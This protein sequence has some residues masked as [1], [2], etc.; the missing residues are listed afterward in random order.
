MAN[1]EELVL[2]ISGDS[3]EAQVSIEELR[4]HLGSLLSTITGGVVSGEVFAHA[5]EQ[6]GEKALEAVHKVVEFYTESVKAAAEYESAEARLAGAVAASGQA[7]MESLDAYHE[8][9]ETIATSTTTSKT[10]ALEMEARFIQLGGVGKDKMGQATQA[11]LDLA[12]GLRIDLTTAVTQVSK[13]LE[14]HVTGLQRMGVVLDAARVQAEGANYIFEELNKRFGGQAQLQAATFAGQIQRIANAWEEFEIAIGRTATEDPV[15]Q[16]ALH[17]L[18]ESLEGV[19][20]ATRKNAGAFTD[21]AA[22]FLEHVM[23]MHGGWY[24]LA[25]AVKYYA[26]QTDLAYEV[27]AMTDALFQKLGTTT[28]QLAAREYSASD[29]AK[30]GLEAFK[31]QQNAVEAIT[32]LRAAQTQGLAAW[33]KAQVASDFAVG[34][35][36][37]VIA[38]AIGANVVVVEKY[39]EQLKHGQEESKKFSQALE[40]ARASTVA[41]SEADQII[42]ATLKERGLSEEQ[43]ALVIG[44]TTA[45][46]KVAIKADEAR[47]KTA[48]EMTTLRREIEKR[49]ND[50]SLKEYEH[51]QKEV[52]AAVDRVVKAIL[53]GDAQ[54]TDL[55]RQTAD[56]V[57]RTTLTSTD[58]QIF[59]INEWAREQKLAFKGTEEERRRFDAA[60]EASAAQQ[61]DALYIDYQAIEKA[62]KAS[63]Q[64]QADKAWTT[65]EFMAER[66]GEF[67]ER[68]I[69]AAR[70]AAE[71]A[72]QAA[73]DTVG[74]W[75]RTDQILG[76]V[77]TI[78]SGIKGKF[79]E[80]TAVV[81]RTF[82][83]IGERLAEGDILGAVVAGITGAITAITK[84][85]GGVSAEEKKARQD[86]ANFETQ[87]HSTLTATQKLEAGNVSWKETTI[88]VRDAYL[89]T[90][91]SEAEAEAAVKRLW[92]SS[93]F[94]A[95]ATKAAID[96]I[97]AV[98]AEQKQRQLDVDAAFKDFTSAVLSAG[99]TLPEALRPMVERLAEMKGL[100]KD[101]R[102]ALLALTKDVAPDFAKLEEIAKK[103]GISLEG[104]G[105]K[106]Q[107]AHIE[108]TAKEIFD[109]FTDLT[110]AGGDVGGVL[111]GMSGKVN[112]LVLDSKHFGAAIPENMKPLIEELLRAGKLTDDDG[113]KMTD[114][115]GVKFE[116][117][118]LDKGT[119][120]IVD[121]INHLGDILSKL[122]G[123]AKT[124]ADG[125]GDALG[126]VSVPPIDVHY[127]VIKDGG[128][129]DAPDFGGAMAAGGVGYV[130]RPTL[131]L[132]GE[133]GREA[134]A[135]SGANKDLGDMVQQ[136][137][138]QQR[139]FSSGAL[140][141]LSV[142]KLPAGVT[143]PASI[144]NNVA[145]GAVQV[146]ASGSIF[147]DRAAMRELAEELQ[148]PLVE[149]LSQLIPGGI[150]LR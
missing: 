84:L 121:A 1:K 31:E 138:R 113:K 108:K 122:P 67:S 45:Q 83:N 33:Q 85:F 13:A 101:E 82:K 23:P 87:L 130:D 55:H 72:Q 16:A 74:A 106:F 110:K 111:V 120:A 95:A 104:L 37:E 70:R 91:R 24:V 143:A 42:V 100:T 65:Y 134:Y 18:T 28:A 54:I 10:A 66:A 97:N 14:G 150:P 56:A 102:D 27:S 129:G 41:L 20:Q 2:K 15:I 26:L 137:A 123:I 103:Y 92:D 60:V 126:H 73:D 139:T 19:E 132:A 146:D 124:A 68:A 52:S 29:A 80:V 61:V 46:V 12:A 71:A 49:A 81:A 133:R 25:D 116:D 140:R 88:A 39:I 3:K 118:P 38:K 90:G 148:A 17:K 93:R 47:T 57:A 89:A 135:F 36:A 142:P 147:R 8:L 96:A 21:Y 76:A 53:E 144:I 112:Q 62:S 145:P 69:E 114:L 30:R 48:A 99:G 35:S 109:D 78:V 44:A 40:Q 6:I 105:P 79:A 75:Q 5:I 32:T 51:W 59:K 7:A 125:I 131:F 22:D 4:T 63:L 128:D 98:L 127:R 94:G 77:D 115:T 107:Q 9:A 11:A 34:A 149:V 58:Y 141:S 136:L 117:T 119:S 43:I 64:E 86:V 50:E